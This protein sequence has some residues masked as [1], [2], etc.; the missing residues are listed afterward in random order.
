MAMISS[1]F[2]AVRQLANDTGYAE[3]RLEQAL[4]R[5]EALEAEVA[6]LTAA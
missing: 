5:I 1:L 3:A 4:N 2:A 6:A